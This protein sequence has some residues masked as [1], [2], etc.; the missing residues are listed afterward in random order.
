MYQ[1]RKERQE[2]KNN[3]YEGFKNNVINWDMPT[4]RKPHSNPYKIK[5]S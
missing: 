2:N 3:N 4:V 5:I 1:K